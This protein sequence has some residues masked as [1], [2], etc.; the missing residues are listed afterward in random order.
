V[1]RLHTILYYHYTL[2]YDTVTHT[3][4]TPLHTLLSYH[5]TLNHYTVTHTVVN[6]YILCV[7]NSVC[8]GA[9]DQCVMIEQ[10]IM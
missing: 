7:D 3:I 8:H 6:H 5:Y 1:S 9:M 2:N 4:I 10:Q